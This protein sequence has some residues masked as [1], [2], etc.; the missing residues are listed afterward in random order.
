MII[1]NFKLFCVYIIGVYLLISICI[2]ILWDVRNQYREQ[3]RKKKIYYF[4]VNP[5]KKKKKL[6]KCMMRYSRND[7]LFDYIC[8][9]FAKEKMNCEE[10][11]EYI[12]QIFKYKIKNTPNSDTYTR[13]LIIKN[14]IRCKMNS[15]FYK[16]YI[17]RYEDKSMLE[18]MWLKVGRES[19]VQK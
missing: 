5:G 18:Q 16:D 10:Y 6:L 2:K 13:C 7:I 17:K 9:G 15:E 11:R 3:K 1:E 14:I 12:N 4:F 19:Y 8:I